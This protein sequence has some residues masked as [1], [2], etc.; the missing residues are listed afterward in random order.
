VFLPLILLGLALQFR[1]VRRDGVLDLVAATA[2]FAFATGTRTA[3]AAFLLIPLL[4]VLFDRRCSPVAAAIRFG[5]VVLMAGLVL[6]VVMAGNWVKNRQ[7]GIGSWT[8]ISLLGKGLLL[9][10][11]S[12][13]PGLPLPVA[14]VAPVTEDLRKLIV[15]QPDLGA[16]LRAQGQAYQDLRFPLFYPAADQ[17]WP[18]WAQADWRTRGTLALALSEQLIVRHP[19]AYVGLWMHDWMALVLYPNYWPRWASALADG[20]LF[21]ACRMHNN[22]WVL[23]RYDVDAKIV[24]VMIGVSLIATAGGCLTLVW[25]S[26]RVLRRRAEPETALFWALALVFQ[27]S[28]LMSSAFE[29]GIAR[30]TEGTHVLGVALLLWFVSLIPVP[31]AAL[32]WCRVPLRRVGGLPRGGL[33]FCGLYLTGI[34]TG[35]AIFWLCFWLGL[36]S[37]IHILFYRGLS[38]IIFATLLHAVTLVFVLWEIHRRGLSSPVGVAYLFPIVLA[39]AALNLAFFVLV[40]V[41]IDRSISVFL[42][43]WMDDH[44]DMPQ[45]KE[46]LRRAFERIY[47]GAYNA[48]DRRIDEQLASGDIV[49]SGNGYVLTNQGTH[50]VSV[51]RGVGHVFATDQRFLHPTVPGGVS[52]PENTPSV[53]QEKPAGPTERLATSPTTI[54]AGNP[55]PAT[56]N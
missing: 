19:W 46:D 15:A 33:F 30:Y 51:V 29:V 40:P 20:A 21:L 8:G 7:F 16:R 48:L 2:C 12:D 42:L 47:V 6:T 25:C 35:V 54:R 56:V 52:Q 31:T 38:L 22:C 45:T 10:E 32:R 28:L 3:A 24:L 26:L 17:S 23:Q 36:L 13:V 49:P 9:I 41:N 50:F 37:S 34:L 1:Y 39:G 55:T 18:A 53:T 27:L 44:H 43:A 4:T 11:P 14:T 5:Q